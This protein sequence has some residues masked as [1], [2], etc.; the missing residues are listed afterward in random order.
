MEMHLL[1]KVSVEMHQQGSVMHKGHEWMEMHL[2][3]KHR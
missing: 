3:H 2:M 1:H